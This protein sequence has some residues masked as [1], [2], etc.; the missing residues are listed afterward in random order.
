MNCTE[1]QEL[2]AAYALGALDPAG[3]G[4]MRAMAEAD[5]DV[6]AELNTFLRVAE[7]LLEGIR[8]VPPPAGARTAVLARIAKTPQLRT[9]ESGSAAGDATPAG[10]RFLRPAEGPWTEGPFPGAR[11]QLLSA[12]WRRNRAMIYLELDPGTRYPDHT[13]GGAEDLYLVTG[14][15]LTAGRLMKAGDFVHCEAGTEH[16]EVVSPSGCQALLVTTMG[17]VIGDFARGKVKAAGSQLA[18]SL[19]FLE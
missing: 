7:R 2:A 11:F 6:R 18:K 14:D 5:P 12:D 16:Q 8:P 4:R 19:G 3:A 13:H 1:I 15:L 17:S 10:F 9:T